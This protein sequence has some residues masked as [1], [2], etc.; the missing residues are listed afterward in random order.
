MF[1]LTYQERKV[2]LF[3][4]VLI[5]TGSFL[6][7]SRAVSSNSNSSSDRN[8][9]NSSLIQKQ[10]EVAVLKREGG[11]TLIDVNK[12]SREELKSIPG[13]GEVIAGR[14]IEYRAKQGLF[15]RVEDLKKIKGISDKKIEIIKKYLSF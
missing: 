10:E 5:L 2:L 4:G 9:V 8:S 13:I 1:C 15:K 7:F 3:V 14:V 12:A 11:I 6:K